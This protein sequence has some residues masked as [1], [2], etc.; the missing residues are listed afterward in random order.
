N[1]FWQQLFGTGL[2]KTTEDLGLQGEPPTHQELL[3]WLAVEFRESGWDV[4]KL[5]KLMVMS[6]TYQQSARVTT[7]RY[8]ADPGNRYYSRGPRHRLDA[9]VLRD[10]AL[11]VSG[12]LVEKIGGPSVKPPQPSGIWE[13]VGYVTSNTANFQADTGPDKVHRRSV[14]TF[15]KRTAPPPQMSAMDAPSR[16]S[17]TV[18]RERTN[19]PL[20]ALLMLNETQYVE[21]ARG[22]AQRSMLAE[23]MLDA[24]LQFMMKAVLIRPA[25]EKELAVLREAYRYQ[26]E[27]FQAEPAEAEKLLAI[28]ESKPSEKLNKPELAAFTM[29]ANIVLN[30]DEAVTK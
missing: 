26:H 4:K 17:C 18:R 10:Q 13:A 8:A 23:E 28:G 24:R 6:N 1:R 27:R 22:L 29:V 12:L 2:V 19:T 9:E 7:E 21:C 16:E 25:E 20:Q 5:M 11:F 3:D 15:W 14:Y 30:L